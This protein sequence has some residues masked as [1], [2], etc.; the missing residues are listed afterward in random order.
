M[1]ESKA[2]AR[3]KKYS[4]F[5]SRDVSLKDLQKYNK[6]WDLVQISLKSNC[7]K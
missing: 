7:E 1:I 4:D 3:G 2:K 5:S 6:G